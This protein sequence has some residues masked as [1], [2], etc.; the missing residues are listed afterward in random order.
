MASAGRAEQRRVGVAEP[1]GACR[2]RCRRA[3]RRT[4]RRSGCRRP[5]CPRPGGAPGRAM[6][7]SMTFSYCDDLEQQRHVDVDALVERLLDRRQ[8]LVGARDLD[9]QVGAVDP[10]PVLRACA[11]VLRC[12]RR[13]R[14]RPPARRSRRS[15]RSRRRPGAGRRRPPGRPGSR[16]PGRSRARVGALVGDSSA[17]CSSYSVEPRIAFSKIAGLEVIAAQ[18]SPPRPAGASSPP[19]VSDRWIWSSQMLV[20]AAVRRARRSLTDAALLMVLP[21]RSLHSILRPI[22]EGN[23][24]VHELSTSWPASRAAPRTPACGP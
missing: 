14:G 24:A 21:P 20:P 11:I 13:G 22:A 7:A 1:P 12:R 15:R 23:P 6:N 18:A 8:A 9:H 17:I 19:W 16:S 10:V 3:R 2:P 4:T 5:A